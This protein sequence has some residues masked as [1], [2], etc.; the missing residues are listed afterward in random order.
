MKKTV[1]H[2][3]HV[4]LGAKMAPFGGFLM[5]IQYSGI[6]AEHKATRAGATL[7]DTCHM[8]EFKVWG[9]NAAKDLDRI[10]SSDIAG[11]KIGKCRNGFFCNNQ[12]GVIDDLI[13]YRFAENEFMIVVNAATQDNDFDWLTSHFSGSTQA[14]NLSE[15]T[16]KIDLQGPKAP[17]IMQE[18]TDSDLSSMK[19]Y[20]HLRCRIDGTEAL[21]SRTGYTGEIGFEMY[22]QSQETTRLWDLFLTKDVLPAGLG[23]R[24]TLRLEL[25]FPLYGHELSDDRNAGESGFMRLITERGGFIGAEVV[26]DESKRKQAL[27]ALGFESRRSARGGEPILDDSGEQIGVVT[28]GSF[29]PSLNTAIGLGYVDRE[30]AGE[31]QR[32]KIK[33]ERS[34]LDATIAEKPFYKDGTARKKITNFL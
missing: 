23:A 10:I 26:L 13:V 7:F 17:S 33:T 14:E 9:P 8:G 6:V 19:F 27:V 18:L 5:P 1:L 15:A 21:I 31:G 32:V 12:G 30:K 28:S 20:D 34:E 22:V 2:D 3:S 16:G 11:L 29:A 24:D 4:K 25:C